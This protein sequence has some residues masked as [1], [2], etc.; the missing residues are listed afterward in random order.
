MYTEG[1]P[2]EIVPFGEVNTTIHLGGTI[3]IADSDDSFDACGTC[4]V[5]YLVSIGGELFAVKMSVGVYEHSR[6]SFVAGSFYF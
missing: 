5:E 3:S 4:A 6:W 1:C 2:D